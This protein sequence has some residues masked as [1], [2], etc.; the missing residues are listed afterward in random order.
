MKQMA[1]EYRLWQTSQPRGAWRGCRNQRGWLGGSDESAWSSAHS[2][3]SPVR[4]T[5]LRRPPHT[6]AK[7]SIRP[8]FA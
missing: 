5:S 1:G 8:R 4:S 2:L 6:D 3:L 7:P